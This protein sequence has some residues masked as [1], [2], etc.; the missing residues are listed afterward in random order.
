LKNSSLKILI[1]IIITAA[2]VLFIYVVLV[3]EI[4]RLNNEKLN[5]QIELNE[6][7]NRIEARIVE[8]QQLSGEDRIVKLAQDS[9]GLFR[10]GKD[11]EIINVQSDQIKKIELLV[12]RKYD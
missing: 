7:T 5:K 6:R 4:K 10:P 8:V 2:A 11:L 12:N 1:P 3:T 9:L